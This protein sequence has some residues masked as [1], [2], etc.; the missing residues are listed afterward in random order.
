MRKI[1][2]MENSTRGRARMQQ[3]VTVTP[4]LTRSTDS[5]T[6]GHG[7]VITVSQLATLRVCPG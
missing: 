7:G 5:E 1:G 3:T 4:R 2:K 6:D